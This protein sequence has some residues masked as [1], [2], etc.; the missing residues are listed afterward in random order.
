MQPALKL[1][2][3]KDVQSVAIHST[4]IQATSK[5]TNQIA[6]MRRLIL[7]FPDRTKHCVGNLMS[8]LKSQ[9]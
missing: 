5:S 6:H 9:F 7:G 8:R 4:N 3:P 1:K 2:T